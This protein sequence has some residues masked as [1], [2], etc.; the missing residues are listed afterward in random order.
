[1]LLS[2]V[3]FFF[4]ELVVGDEEMEDPKVL[5]MALFQI[6]LGLLEI[7]VYLATIV[8]FL[9]WL[10]RS[11]ENLPAFGVRKN[12][13]QY[14]SGWAVGSFFI[15][16]ASLV[17]PY[18]AIK[19]LWR[20]SVP[21]TENFFSDPSP[22]PFFPLWWAV[23]L[24]S[25]FANQIY[26]RVSW[27]TELAPEVSSLAGLLTAFLD[28]LAAILALMVVREIDRQQ[29]ANEKLMPGL[30]SPHPPRPPVLQPAAS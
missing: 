7:V 1:M 8:T 5:I 9:L 23:W 13:L 25:N 20:K 10:H 15:P 19:E 24:I 11:Y 18:R 12:Q 16:F 30:V 28:L 22:P 29:S 27:R 6:G 4:P 2:I 17:I 21:N 14:S 3:E 26:F